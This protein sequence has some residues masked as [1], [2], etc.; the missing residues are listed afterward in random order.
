MQLSSSNAYE[1]QE[2]KVASKGNMY[3]AILAKGY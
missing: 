1:Q 3:T 2:H